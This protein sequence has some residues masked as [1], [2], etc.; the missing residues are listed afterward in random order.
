M[1]WLERSSLLRVYRIPCW[2][3]VIGNPS[4]S[5]TFHYL[6]L[7]AAGNFNL[8]GPFPIIW[9]LTDTITI[10]IITDPKERKMWKT[11]NKI[12]LPIRSSTLSDTATNATRRPMWSPSKSFLDFKPSK[13]EIQ[14]TYCLIQSYR[15][16]GWRSWNARQYGDSQTGQKPRPFRPTS[17]RVVGGY[18]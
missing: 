1:I 6:K 18:G 15:A 8:I 16:I 4:G 12:Y 14:L 3:N 11:S 9:R 10:D 5:E 13:N 17:Q 2:L 7:C